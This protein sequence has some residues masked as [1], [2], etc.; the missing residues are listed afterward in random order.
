METVTLADRYRG[1]L[2]GLACGDALGGPFEFCSREQ[3]ARD[4]P[5]GPREFTGGGWLDL[6]PGEV[7]DDTQMALAVGHA[8][9]HHGLDID[10]LGAAFLAWYRSDPKDIG[11]IT[12]AALARL[13]LGDPWWEAGEKIQ[14][15]AGPRGAAGNGSVMRCAP[16]ALR[17][18]NDRAAL[19]QATRGSSKIT[20]ADPR[21]TDSAVAVNQAIVHLLNGHSVAGVIEAAIVGIEEPS[22]RDT[23]LQ[24]TAADASSVRSSGYV[25]HTVGASFWCLVNHGTLEEA[26]VAA[27]SLG[28]DTDTTGAVVGALA[29]AAYGIHAIPTRWLDQVQ[30][31]AELDQLATSLLTWAEA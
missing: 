30:Y 25:L 16:L 2:L 1:S 10:R 26:V 17:F 7:T 14:A 12:R 20:H 23:I 22:V 3:I 24:A 18:R 27:V 15:A 8:C 6:A 11:N 29:G 28:D 4:F 19:I 9:N 21:C 5:S 31:R 13:A